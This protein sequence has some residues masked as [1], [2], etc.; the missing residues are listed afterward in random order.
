MTIDHTANDRLFGKNLT[1]YG[2]SKMTENTKLMSANYKQLAEELYET[3]K[4][5]RYW[6]ISNTEV[7]DVIS[8]YE[9]ET[10]RGTGRTTALYHKAITEALENPGKSVEFIDHYPH[11][12]HGVNFHRERLEKIINKLGYNI[13]VSTKGRAQVYLYNRFG[14]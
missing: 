1:V 10:T 5:V 12:W 11:T 8:K 4:K 9:Q 3:L 7:D 2:E 6:G 14:Q 13:V